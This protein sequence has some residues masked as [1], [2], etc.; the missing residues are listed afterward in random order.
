MPVLGIE[1]TKTG[2]G[3]KTSGWIIADVTLFKVTSSKLGVYLWHVRSKAC[4]WSVADIYVPQ[5][6]VHLQQLDL[7]LVQAYIDACLYEP[8][9]ISAHSRT[10][11]YRSWRLLL[12]SSSCSSYMCTRFPCFIASCASWIVADMH[13]LF[14][15]LQVKTTLWT[16]KHSLMDRKSKAEV[17]DMRADK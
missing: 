14:A 16:Q 12:L 3:E 6:H 11:S 9:P 4:A 15:K 5:Q 17:I 2:S 7:Q 8:K 13:V 10:I 1:R